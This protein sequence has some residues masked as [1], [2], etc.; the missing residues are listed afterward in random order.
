LA[1]AILANNFEP[2][3]ST[4]NMAADAIIVRLASFKH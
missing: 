3:A 4:I 1:L 2:P